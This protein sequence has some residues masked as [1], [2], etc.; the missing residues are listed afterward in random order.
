MST[1]FATDSHLVLPSVG[2]PLLSLLQSFATVLKNLVK[3]T[4]RSEPGRTP[5]VGV[6]FHGVTPMGFPQSTRPRPELTPSSKHGLIT[7]AFHHLGSQSSNNPIDLY[8][9]LGRFVE[10][11]FAAIAT[12]YWCCEENNSYNAQNPETSAQM[13][14]IVSTTQGSCAWRRRCCNHDQFM[15]PMQIPSVTRCSLLLFVI[16]IAVL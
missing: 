15:L 13:V 6:S 12:M 16:L 9:R 14:M 4:L 7:A 1:L 10:S 11:D 2:L 5:L 3:N 8:A